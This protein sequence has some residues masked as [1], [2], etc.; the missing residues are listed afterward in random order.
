MIS[1]LCSRMSSALTPYAILNQKSEARA[2]KW[3][4]LR[5]AAA[6]DSK[7]AS[8]TVKSATRRRTRSRLFCSS[9]RKVVFF[10]LTLASSSAKHSIPRT[11]KDTFSSC[12]IS[13]STSF[14]PP[15]GSLPVQAR[16]RPSGRRFPALDPGTPL[17]PG[18]CVP[19]EDLQHGCCGTL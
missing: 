12:R 1:P 2:V 10:A 18:A 13:S 15:A 19:L 7:L 6:I 8:R 14:R 9:P 16:H 5:H 4:G 11:G 3:C 17:L